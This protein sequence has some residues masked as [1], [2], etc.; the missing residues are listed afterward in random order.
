[1]FG[2][3][4]QH[5][6]SFSV[7][8]SPLLSSNGL[9]QSQL[10]GRHFLGSRTTASALTLAVPR[11][12]DLGP[13]PVASSSLSCEGHDAVGLARLKNTVEEQNRPFG[14]ILMF[15]PVLPF[16]DPELFPLPCH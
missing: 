11:V 7:A 14:Q 12:D 3:T 13:D 1:M 10:D 15:L 16:E 2:L 9:T 6:Y 5:R 8:H 4:D